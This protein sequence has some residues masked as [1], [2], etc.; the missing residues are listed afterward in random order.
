MKFEHREFT[1]KDGRVCVLCPTY[2]EYAEEMIEYLRITAAETEFVLRYPDEV[3]YTLEGEKEILGRL[4]EDEGSIMMLAIVDGK[5]AGNASINGL[6]N[7]RKIFHRCSLAIA[8]KKEY[9]NLGI[10]KAM[11]EYLTELAKL[12]GYE[13]ID[14][15]V[16]EGNDNAK[17]LY[18]KCGFIETGK[19]ARAL[20][21]DDGTY[22]DEIIMSKLL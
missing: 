17:N 13:Q 3:N 1:L 9:W 18:R 15:E 2:P 12:I 14:L 7:K 21:F 8:L 5:V 10:G 4:L 11:I 16:V 19:R 22:H 6:G 20:K